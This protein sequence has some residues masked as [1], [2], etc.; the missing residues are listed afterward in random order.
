MTAYLSVLWLIGVKV[1][2]NPDIPGE[3]EAGHVISD[4]NIPLLHN[5]HVEEVCERLG[6]KDGNNVGINVGEEREGRGYVGAENRALVL[7]YSLP[8]ECLW[9]LEPEVVKPVGYGP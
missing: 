6:V 5:L 8:K 9:P 1:S 7:L 4:K 2:T 3:L